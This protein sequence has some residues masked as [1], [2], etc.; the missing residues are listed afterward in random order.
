MGKFAILGCNLLQSSRR[1]GHL[2]LIAE[3]AW[4]KARRRADVVRPLIKRDR[5][6]RH[7]VQAAAAELGLSERRTYTLLRRCREAGG[8][9]T[10]LVPDR[11][12]GSRNRPRLGL[13]SEAALQR[14]VKESYLTPQCR[15][16]AGAIEA[17]VGRPCRGAAAIFAEHHPAPIK[18]LS[19]AE[20]GRR[21]E[22]FPQAKPVHPHAPVGRH[23]LDL[24]QMDHTPVDL[25]LVDPI[26]L[27]PIGNRGSQSPST[28]G[29][30]AMPASMCHSKPRR[31]VPSRVVWKWPERVISGAARDWIGSGC[32]V[33]RR[34]GCQRLGEGLPTVDLA[35]G[36]LA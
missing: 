21:G 32:E 26:D 6:P 1:H 16:V 23:V 9:L 19:L 13:A 14:I 27:E 24:V 8:A 31:R 35:H 34:D 3:A 10:A 11:S 12:S 33:N 28:R 25:I 15:S 30:G 2:T 18:A 17:V 7:L 36:D 5:R 4:C 20:R 29:A 22:E